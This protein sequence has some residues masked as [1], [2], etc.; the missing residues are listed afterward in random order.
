MFWWIGLAP[1]EVLRP[2]L[3]RELKSELE[4][5]VMVVWMFG[6]LEGWLVDDPDELILEDIVGS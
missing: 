6:R 1:V 3:P 5:M 4:D 2:A